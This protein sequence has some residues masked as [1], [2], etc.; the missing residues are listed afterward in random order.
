MSLT[1]KVQKITKVGTEGVIVELTNGSAIAY[2]KVPHRY[3][4]PITDEENN[5]VGVKEVE[6]TKVRYCVLDTS[7]LNNRYDAR[8]PAQNLFLERAEHFSPEM[9]LAARGGTTSTQTRHASIE[10]EISNCY[11]QMTANLD[12]RES[13]FLDWMKKPDWSTVKDGAVVFGMTAVYTLIWPINVPYM[14]IRGMLGYEDPDRSGLYKFM[15]PLILLSIPLGTI[16]ELVSPSNNPAGRQ[17]KIGNKSMLTRAPDCHSP[18]ITFPCQSGAHIDRFQFMTLRFK[19]NL[20]V[21]KY[22]KADYRGIREEVKAHQQDS[23]RALSKECSGWYLKTDKA[24]SERIH[25]LEQERDALSKTCNYEF[26][27][28]LAKADHLELLKRI[29]FI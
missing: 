24:A 4:Q 28:Q 13:G 18:E 21:T 3:E 20:E 15:A 14:M 19:G 10:Q 5:I 9:E 1:E 7:K 29:E 6:G 17:Y 12:I 11:E 8:L 27:K 22:A 26:K 23:E 2:E 25:S 16:K